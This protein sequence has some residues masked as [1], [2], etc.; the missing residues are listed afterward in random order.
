MLDANA[1]DAETSFDSRRL[2]RELI[3]PQD[4]RLRA[5]YRRRPWRAAASVGRCWLL[6]VAALALVAWRPTPAVAALAF[7]VVGTQQYALTILSHDAKHRNLFAAPRWNDA[8]GLWLLSAPV[9]A[10][11]SAER[12]RHLSHH[13]RLGHDD[14]PDRDLYRASDKARSAEFLRYV[15]GL[16]TLPGFRRSAA[17]GERGL[18]W[19]TRLR[20]LLAERWPAL[21][22]NALFVALFA[23]ALDWRLYF[24]LWGAPLFLFMFVPV[25]IRQFCEHAQPV[26]PD[27]AADGERLVTYRATPIERLLIAP[28]HMDHHAEHHLWPGVPYYNLPRLAALVPDGAPIERRPGYARFLADYFR[29]LPLE[30]ARSLPAG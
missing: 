30:P 4:P 16:T 15:S 13:D 8:V 27:H 20:R 28:F 11:F 7:L 18:D 21:A 22:V 6:I 3:D 25:R 10:N 24:V 26:L 9:G 23:L 2:A 12:T 29:S 14:D 5:L 19:P 17:R 1:M